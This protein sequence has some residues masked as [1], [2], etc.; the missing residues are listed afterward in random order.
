[1]ESYVTFPVLVSL[2]TPE[3]ETST[4]LLVVCRFSLRGRPYKGRGSGQI[5]G[6]RI[7]SLRRVSTPEL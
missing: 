7:N 6:R 3:I 1:M 5:E 4:K 2:G